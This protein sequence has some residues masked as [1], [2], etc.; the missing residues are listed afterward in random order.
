MVFDM[1]MPVPTA[2]SH[3]GLYSRLPLLLT[4]SGLVLSV[5]PCFLHSPPRLLLSARWKQRTL[6]AYSGGANNSLMEGERE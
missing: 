1:A 3:S 5:A 4:T 2:H 6:E